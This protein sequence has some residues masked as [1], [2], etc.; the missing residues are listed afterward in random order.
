MSELDSTLDQREVERF[1]ALAAI[2]WD[3]DGAFA[4]LHAIGPERTRFLRDALVRH[5]GR[6]AHEAQPL[7]GLSVADIGCGGGLVAEPMARLGAHV[8]GIDPAEENVAAA[9]AHAQQ[10]GL[11]IDYRAA[12][13]EDLAAESDRFD[14]VIALEVV[15]H[16]PDVAAF[17]DVCAHVVRPGGLM[18][19]STI[20][21]TA[22]A[23]ALAIVG[24]EYVLRWLPRGTHQWDRFVTPAEL[25]EALRASG[26]RVVDTRGLTFNPLTRDWRLSSNTSVN[27]F[28]AAAKAATKA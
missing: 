7:E 23:F 27:Y 26:L 28:L 18:L 22:K 13:V 15:E 3:P 17:I 10:S 4:P 14:A 21:R 1:R 5:F 12:R 24:A 25:A 16:V 20:N 9:R 11:Q 8:T 19:L 2:W 6:D